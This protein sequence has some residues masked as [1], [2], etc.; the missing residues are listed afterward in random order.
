MPPRCSTSDWTGLVRHFRR[1]T[2]TAAQAGKVGWRDHDAK[3]VAASL[4]F[5]GCRVPA[6][7]EFARQV[8]QQHGVDIRIR[9]RM[10]KKPGTE[11]EPLGVRGCKYGPAIFGESELAKQ[12]LK[13]LISRGAGVNLGMAYPKLFPRVTPGM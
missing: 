1:T 8:E 11:Q 9:K 6:R 10:Q 12:L 13:V 7:V 5:V 4:Q 2:E 3:V